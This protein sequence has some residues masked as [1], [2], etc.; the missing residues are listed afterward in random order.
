MKDFLSS[1]WPYIIVA[2]VYVAERAQYLSA[3]WA[4]K[5][6]SLVTLIRGKDLG[7]LPR[8][9]ESTREAMSDMGLLHDI[10]IDS[11]LDN[12]RPESTPRVSRGKKVLNGL[13]KILPFVTRFKK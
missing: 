5:I 8:G 9:V 12:V 4:N 13:L 11:A 2:I 10:T 1:N 3:D 7:V 6:H